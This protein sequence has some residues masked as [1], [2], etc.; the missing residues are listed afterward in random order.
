M[1]TKWTRTGQTAY[2]EATKYGHGV[3]TVATITKLPSGKYRA[4][5]R[6]KNQY[7]A[8][9]F[10]TKSAA[11]R[12]SSQIEG[13]LHDTASGIKRK[14]PG[15]TVGDLVKS[16]TESVSNAPGATVGRTKRNTL[17]M[18]QQRF[19]NVRL[20]NIEAGLDQFIESRLKEGAGGV[21]IAADLSFLSTVLRWAAA[22]KNIAVDEL[23]ARRARSTLSIR[24]M[25]TRSQ[26]RE[27]IPAADELNA[28]YAHWAKMKKQQIPME[29]IVKFAL[30]SGMRQAEICRV[31]I[32]DIDWKGKTVLIRQRKDPKKKATN[33]QVIPL[34]GDS[35][36][37]AKE[38]AGKRTRGRLFPYNSRSVST[39]FQLAARD[40]GFPD[41]NF[42]DLRHAATTAFFR[43]GLP[44][45][46]VA[47]I[48]GHKS[49]ENL[50]RY[51]QLKASDVHAFL[52]GV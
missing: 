31:L 14:V 25:E 30:A 23:A 12:W 33:D 4:R 5:V 41:L 47:L 21:T 38:Q 49:W 13:Q 6:V 7:R 28:M 27:R 52:E 44:I 3:D 20:E 9:T 46:L 36:A 40:L 11:R 32:E 45:Q 16:Y 18:L 42:H 37:I 2:N 15:M 34:V 8:S 35:L 29:R 50:R 43:M 10:A 1:D 22:V 24:G 39:S 19:A 26:Q 48:T 17:N 51:T